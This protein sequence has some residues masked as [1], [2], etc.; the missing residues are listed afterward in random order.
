ML[1]AIKVCLVDDTEVEG[2]RY[3]ELLSDSDRLLTRFT[4]PPSDLDLD[5]FFSEDVGLFLIDYELIGRQPNRPHA[6]YYGGTLATALRQRSPDTPLVLLTRRTLALWHHDRP[7]VEPSQIFDGELYKDEIDDDLDRVVKQLSE[8]AKGFILLKAKQER[9]WDELLVALDASPEEEAALLRE[10]NPPADGWTTVQASRWIRHVILQYPGVLY[11]NV[12]AA[13]ALGISVESFTTTEL[14]SFLHQARYT[15]VFSPID[16]RWWRNRLFRLRENIVSEVTSGELSRLPFRDAFQRKFQIELNHAVSVVT[17]KPG[18]D[19][20][21]YILNQPAEI[22]NTLVYYP[23]N[24]PS[25]MD[26]AR[27][28][29]K[30]IR[31]S[32]YVK[33][34]LFDV[35]SGEL[36]E[37][38]R[39]NS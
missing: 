9:N 22:E 15:G 5:V 32:P 23:D 24:R 1:M 7:F 3:A 2:L 25:V 37:E 10:A 12:H 30:A 33:D 29:F 21:C 36:L 31:E 39:A 28:S 6:N 4:F 13:T 8:L 17:E 35:E 11:D 20:V 14:Q 27:V 16:G 18:A 26:E 34:E 38:I 19:W